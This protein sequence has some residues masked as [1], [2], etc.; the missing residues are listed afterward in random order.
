MGNMADI[1]INWPPVKQKV[2]NPSHMMRD[3]MEWGEGQQIMAIKVGSMHRIM[4]HVCGWEESKDQCS[5]NLGSPKR[6]DP[7]KVSIMFILF[8]RI[9][10]CAITM[11]HYWRAHN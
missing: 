3:L 1:R 2:A 9:H 7:S 8:P 6:K 10:L 5:I 4:D 11:L